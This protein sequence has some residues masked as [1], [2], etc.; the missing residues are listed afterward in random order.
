MEEVPPEA[1]VLFILLFV[2]STFLLLKSAFT[3][4]LEPKRQL[5]LPRRSVTRTLLPVDLLK[6]GVRR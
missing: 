1:I 2:G 6:K 3:Q 5:L 4:E